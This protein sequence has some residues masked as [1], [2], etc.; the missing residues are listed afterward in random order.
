MNYND[1]SNKPNENI[2]KNDKAIV[3]SINNIL[4]TPTGTMPGHPEFGCSVGKY[5]FEQLDI[6]TI[7]LIKEEVKYALAR[8]ELRI[9]VSD[10]IVTEDLDYNRIDIKIIYSIKNDIDNPDREYI[11][12]QKI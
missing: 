4:G 5:L 3:N 7:Q 2:D 1:I 9:D 10:V 8:W 6:L 11:Y 12:S